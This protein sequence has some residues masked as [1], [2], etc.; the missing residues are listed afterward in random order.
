LKKVTLPPGPV[1]VPGTATVWAVAVLPVVVDA[2]ELPGF[3][4]AKRYADFRDIQKFDQ[5][6]D[7]IVVR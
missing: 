3:L 7:W 2:C 1:G 6:L 5:S 4:Q